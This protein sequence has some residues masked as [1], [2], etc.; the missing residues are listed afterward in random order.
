VATADQ[1]AQLV[2][3]PC[4]KR[5]FLRVVVVPAA[6]PAINAMS[7]PLRLQAPSGGVI[8]VCCDT[9]TTTAG[10]AR[11]R[12]TALWLTYGD[13]VTVADVVQRCAPHGV[14]AAAAVPCN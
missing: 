11:A 4:S 13:Q 14:C 9:R 12:E 2:M 7:L 5:V 1:A 10:R 8:I 3:R 6:V